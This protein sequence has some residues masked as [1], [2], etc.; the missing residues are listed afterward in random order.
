[1]VDKYIIKLAAHS[2]E[3]F[4]RMRCESSIQL[5]TVSVIV[6]GPVML[7]AWCTVYYDIFKIIV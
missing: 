3:A 6:Y 5:I 7:R 1:M 2:E 4:F